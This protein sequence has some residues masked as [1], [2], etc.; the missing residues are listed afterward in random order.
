LS[1]VTQYR[2]KPFELIS[3]QEIVIHNSEYN[4]NTNGFCHIDATNDVE[5]ITSWLDEFSD[6]P[7]TWRN[8]RKEAERLLLWASIT[9]NKSLSGLTCEDFRTYQHF[10]SDP[11]PTSLWCGPR[12]ERNSPAWKPFR[13]PLGASSQ[14]QAMVVINAL[15]SYLVQAGYLNGNPLSLIR[16]RSQ[17]INNNK[18][19]S[20]AIERFLDAETWE[21]L[22]NYISRMPQA[23]APQKARY[24]RI[25]FLFHFLYLLAPRVSEVCSHSM[26]SFREYRGKWWWF[27]LGK[28]NKF[29]KVPINNEMLDALARYRQFL[30]LTDLPETDEDT[31]L[32]RS[33]SGQ[34]SVTSNT[35]YRL[36]K[37]VVKGAADAWEPENPQKAAKLRR[38]STHWFRHTSIT[39][40]DDAGISLK[41]LNRNARH[42]KLETTAIYQHAEDD[43]WHDETQKHVY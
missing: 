3:K 37:S 8:Y 2:P 26:N 9:L 35:V 14:K 18:D 36:V 43:N 6:S 28:G 40:Q 10:L 23:T 29:A 17:K 21:H 20:I 32:L 27:A 7:E 15:L 39:H 41:Y 34:R 1:F 16:R 33:V 13:G 5:A 24:E 4:R 31:P 38:A 12:A 25:R 42:S 22:K 11:T 30:G 19:N